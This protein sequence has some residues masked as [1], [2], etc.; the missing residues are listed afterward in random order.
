MLEHR[1]LGVALAKRRQ[2]HSLIGGR[3]ALRDDERSPAGTQQGDQR[4][5]AVTVGLP[6]QVG[7]VV[8]QL[9]EDVIAVADD[10]TVEDEV[11]GQLHSGLGDRRG[12]TDDQ[13]ELVDRLHGL[14]DLAQHHPAP[15]ELLLHAPCGVVD[16]A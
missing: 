1:T 14:T 16:Q 12:Q 8:R 15:V 5:V 7:A 11:T 3:P 2:L 13:T 9:I 10:L 6:G 4:R